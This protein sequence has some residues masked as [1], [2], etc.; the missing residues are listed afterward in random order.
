MI[1]RGSDILAFT[2]TFGNREIKETV[3]LL[4]ATA[5]CWFDWMVCAGASSEAQRTIL[6]RAL[7]DPRKM[8]IQYLLTWPEN[9]GQ[10]HAFDEALR[11]ARTGYTWLLRLDDDIRPKTKKWLTRMLDHLT[12]LKRLSGDEHYRLVAS[13][14]IVGLQNPIVPE[15]TI[16]KG[17][18]FQAEICTLLGGAC[19][20]HPVALLD[21]F[22]PDLYAP[23][24]RGDP[25]ALAT[26]LE[27]KTTGY[28]VRFP[29]IRMVHNTTLIESNDTPEEALQR[30]MGRVWCYLGAA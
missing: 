6:D 17:Q 2:P 27:E 3:A 7:N 18:K 23:L 20:L 22:K 21:D 15:G 13:P 14:K 24:G 26:Y 5:G 28:Q 11:V 30:R 25:Q 16:E 1:E 9:R 12:D 10:H 29:G 19:R 8:G 4:R